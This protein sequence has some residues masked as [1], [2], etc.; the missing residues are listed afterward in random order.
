MKDKIK[1][2]IEQYDKGGFTYSELE[3]ELLDLFSVVWRSEPFSPTCVNGYD[4]RE[5]YCSLKNKCIK[6]SD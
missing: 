6:C 3:F 1:F 5:S 4:G 2:L